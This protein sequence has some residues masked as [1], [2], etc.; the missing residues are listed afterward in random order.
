MTDARRGA[1]AAALA[2]VLFGSAYVATAFAIRSFA[3]L[4][5][6]AWRSGLAA[7]LMAVWLAVERRRTGSS[8]VP[9]S[10]GRL[11]RLAVLGALG[12]LV[13]LS[14]MNLAVASVG[15]TITSFVAGLYAVLA[16]VLAW[17]ILG[18]RVRPG[19]IAGF[20]LA[21]VGALLLAELDPARTS[22]GGLLAALG[23]ALSFALF[24]ALSRRWSAR[25]RLAP[26]A[27]S[28]AISGLAAI[29]TAA[30]GAATAPAPLGPADGRADALVAIV[31]LGLVSV[32]AQVLVVVGVRNLRSDRSSAFLLLNPIAATILAA[33]L[34]GERLAP[35]QLLGG[36]LVLAGIA[37]AT[38]TLAALRAA[39]VGRS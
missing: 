20:V 21:L 24:L 9:W 33:G 37:L 4:A 32:V 2:A 28:F 38:G 17:P 13:F 14:G 36:A 35:G 22:G 25:Y 26:T 11:A 19:A 3:P 23:A 39:A 30:F 15:A 34:L 10:A 31:W 8:G 6:V 29:G 5:A 16:A 12:G 7:I 18:E 1:L 27:V